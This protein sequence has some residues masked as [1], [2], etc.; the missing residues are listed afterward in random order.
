MRARPQRLRLR[1][2]EPRL[3]RLLMASGGPT[4]SPDVEAMKGQLD[5]AHPNREALRAL[6]AGLAGVAS[7]AEIVEK[8]HGLL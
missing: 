2:A 3:T 1:L 6:A 5:K 7:M 8:L 4:R